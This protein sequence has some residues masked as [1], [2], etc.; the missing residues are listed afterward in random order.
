MD[1]QLKSIWIFIGLVLLL[2]LVAFLPTP[3]IIMLVVTLSS[4]LIVWQ[5]VIVLK[6]EG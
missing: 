1:L 5:V 2:L 3:T 6:D 4:I